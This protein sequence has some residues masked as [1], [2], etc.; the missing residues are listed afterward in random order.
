MDRP[1]FI[2]AVNQNATTSAKS[3]NCK[4]GVIMHI[5]QI[6]GYKSSGKTTIMN[7][8]IRYFSGIGLRVGSLKHHG[9]GGEP[10]MAEG[11]DSRQHFES[12]SMISG[13]EGAGVT[14]LMLQM[15]FELDD[16]I[17][18]YSKFPLDLLLIEG[19]KKADYRKVVLIKNE[20]DLSLLQELSNIIAIG[21]WDMN[22][23]EDRGCP[24]FD[25]SN[26]QEDIS[27]LAE[28]IRRGFNG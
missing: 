7:Q 9:H 17:Q 2:T 8:L 11:T 20:A 18:M 26:L 22:L 27:A 16:L 19:Y 23:L 21:T 13:V 1:F 4:D 28:Y 15:P 24:V 10:D 25:M 3:A 6:T 5:C 12:G 14:Q